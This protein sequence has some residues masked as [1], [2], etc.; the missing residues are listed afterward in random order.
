MTIRDFDI[1]KPRCLSPQPS[2]PVLLHL[3]GKTLQ[4]PAV[5]DPVEKRKQNRQDRIIEPL[6]EP[7]RPQGMNSSTVGTSI[8]FYPDSFNPAFKISPHIPMP[9]KTTP[10][11]SWAPLRPRPTIIL[12]LLNQPLYIY[13]KMEYQCFAFCGW[14]VGSLR[15]KINPSGHPVSINRM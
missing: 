9:P 15:P 4:V 11:T 10:L 2:P 14:S 8:A 7:L 13:R 3:T 12:A 1:V 6:V 5:D